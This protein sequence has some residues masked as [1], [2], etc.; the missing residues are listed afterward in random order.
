MS[1][2]Y[3]NDFQYKTGLHNV[4][5]YQ[6][7][8]APWATSSVGVP[9]NTDTPVQIDFPRVTKFVV[10]KNLTS[11][12]LRV[13]FS[14]NGVKGSNYFVLTNLESFSGDLKLSRIFL[15][16]NTATVTSAS[17]IAGLT[18]ID[19]SQLINNWSGSAGVG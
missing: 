5:S 9:G 18:G 10:I 17:V 2:N 19:S 16:G 13:G 1:D 7:S 11:S 6:V 4:G 15:L 14:E 12:P 8:A 3:F